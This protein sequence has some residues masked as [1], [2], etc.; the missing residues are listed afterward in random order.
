VTNPVKL[1]IGDCEPLSPHGCNE[2]NSW[3]LEE[4][5]EILTGEPALQPHVL[6][7]RMPFLDLR[8]NCPLVSYNI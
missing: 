8:S 7:N 6:C 3:H 2:S 4:Q 1:V 5:P